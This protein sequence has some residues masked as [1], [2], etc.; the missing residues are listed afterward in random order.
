MAW[1]HNSGLI[2]FL[3]IRRGFRHIHSFNP[4]IILFTFHGNGVKLGFSHHTA[5]MFPLISSW[6]HL[7]HYVVVDY[8]DDDDGD[9]DDDDDD[10]GD[11]MTITIIIVIITIII[12]MMI[13]LVV[14]GTNIVGPRCW[15]A[16]W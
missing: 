1:L 8:D 14:A 6:T 5:S 2:I 10:D 11:R 9:D 4:K 12:T 3:F 16:F 13:M 15:W 7:L